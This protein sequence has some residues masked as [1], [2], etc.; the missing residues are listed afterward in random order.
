MLYYLPFRLK[1]HNP[2][3]LSAGCQVIIL[4]NRVLFVYLSPGQ[5]GKYFFHHR[6]PIIYYPAKERDIIDYRVN[7]LGIPMN[8][9]GI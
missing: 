8:Q 9:I 1:S 7:G 6:H 5:V 4:Y 3:L 2:T